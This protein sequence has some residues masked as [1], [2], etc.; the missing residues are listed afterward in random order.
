MALDPTLLSTALIAGG[1]LVGDA[2]IKEMT[3][4]AYQALKGKVGDLFGRRA[5][6]ATDKLEAA[7]TRDEGK[8]ELALAIPDL[9]PDEADEIRPVL[10]T[11]LDAMGQD[12]AAREGLA[13]ARIAL[14]LDVGG[15]VLI[16][17]VQDAREI[18]VRSRSD[19]DFTFSNVR[20]DTGNRSGN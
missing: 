2:T 16:D 18:G 1:T 19:G 8:A 10:Q 14:D 7:D 9:R 12:G 15:N 11:F 17:N 20:M 13:H 6:K 5:L 3:K 4:D